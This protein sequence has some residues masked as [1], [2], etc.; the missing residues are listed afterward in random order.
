MTTYPSCFVTHSGLGVRRLR[1]LRD[2][3]FPNV[4]ARVSRHFARYALYKLFTEPRLRVRAERPL[5][6]HNHWSSGYHHWLTESVVKLRFIDSA[7]HQILL[8]ADYP[9]FAAESL[10]LFD[11]GEVLL[12]PRGRSVATRNLTVVANPASGNFNPEQIGW[13]KRELTARCG[14]ASD[15]VR[16]I[17]ITRSNAPLRKVENEDAVVSRM[18]S[19][20]FEVVDPGELSF[21]DQ[22]KLFAQCE[23]LVSVHGAGLTNCLFMPEGGQVLELYRERLPGGAA[24][25]PCYENLA[26]A[27]RLIYRTQFCKHGANFGDHIDRVNVIVD[28]DELERNVSLMLAR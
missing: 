5:L 21:C 23:A 7:S 19:L 2:T 11:C 25:N 17:Y 8:P 12:V 15:S 3:S 24:M 14:S 18:T 26:R 20:G 10:S 13:L 27:A 28:V 16:R 1:L 22:V 9:R 4:P 6:I